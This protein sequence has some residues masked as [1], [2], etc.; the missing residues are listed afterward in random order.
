MINH[1]FAAPDYAEHLLA[2]SAGYRSSSCAA[3]LALAMARPSQL[4][5]RL[6]SILDP[7]QN[8][9][10]LS[11][12]RMTLA[13]VGA[14]TLLSALSV[15]R[16]EATAA[17]GEQQ[18]QKAVENAQNAPADR[19]ATDRAK[20][21][22]DL[23]AKIT[24][25]YVTPVNEQEIVQGA[26]KGMLGALHDP[27]SDYLTPEMV[28]EME[29]QIGGTLVGI[30]AQLELRDRQIRVVTPLQDSPALKAGIQPGDV[31][32]QVD[33]KSVEGLSVLEVVKRIAG[34]QGTTVRLKIGREGG[35]KKK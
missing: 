29:R 2:V 7:S 35:A 25:Q 8:R 4:E 27:Y 3:G 30:G 28:A 10:S 6:L 22:A 23:R 16:V 20:T 31:I 26:I 12:R 15:L 11:P 13:A 34:P 33:D 9:G 21:L 14:L 19:Q 32:L 24:E 18:T 17:G 5:R 1:G